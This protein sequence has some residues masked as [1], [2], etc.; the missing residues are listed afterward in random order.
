MLSPIE[1][2]ALGCGEATLPEAPQPGRSG[3][4]T[5]EPQPG[6]GLVRQSAGWPPR[7]K[8]RLRHGSHAH[9]PVSRPAGSSSSAGNSPWHRPQ[10]RDAGGLTVEEDDDVDMGTFRV[11]SEEAG[12]LHWGVGGS[13]R[14][15]QA[16]RPFQ[17]ALAG[18]RRRTHAQAGSGDGSGG[19]VLRG[20]SIGLMR[21][22]WLPSGSATM[23]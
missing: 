21:P 2:R 11:S 12:G 5:A 23:A 6:V 17:G 9:Q 7:P 20:S 3:I 1:L 19:Q 18:Y 14:P 15:T 8:S 13:R 16:S 10:I 4:R 22:T